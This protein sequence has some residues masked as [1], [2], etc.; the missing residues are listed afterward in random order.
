M[1]RLYGFRANEPTKVECTLVYAQ[2]ALMM[3]SRAD[4][5]GVSHADGWGI[6]YYENASP[7]LER[8][9]TAAYE[10]AHFSLT[11]ERI[12]ASTVVGHVRLA[13]VG[14]TS[15]DNTHPFTRGVWIFAHNGTVTAF[16]A[17][18][19]RL[20]AETDRDL[21]AARRGTT[22]SEA[23]FS[24]LLTRMR[25]RDIDADRC[26]TDVVPLAELVTTAVNDL[27]RWCEEAGA[28]EA[29]RLNFLLTDGRVMVASR[30]N[31]SLHWLQRDGVRD[32]EICG[33]P[34]VHH[35]T[36][37]SYRAVVIASE[38]ISHEAW[39]EVDEGTIVSVDA[40]LNVLQH[41]LST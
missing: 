33:I 6:G 37:T 17:V 41:P 3:Q 8:R 7:R 19:P 15:I 35:Q 30:W 28:P 21:L 29:P 31:N 11:A 2:N 5:R 10:D 18:K 14:A 24:W 38:P 26:V 27:R 40:R 9:E 34:H 20:D 13:T 23:T 16:D 39:K 32:C 1:C 25:A 36:G 22:D 4:L 12:Y